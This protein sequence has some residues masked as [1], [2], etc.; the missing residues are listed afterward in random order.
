MTVFT[1]YKSGLGS[2]GSYQVSGRPWITGSVINNDQHK[3]SFPSV[4]KSVTVI[5]T[6]ASGGGTDEILVHFNATGSGRVIAGNHFHRLYSK[7]DNVTFNVK[8]KEIY[9]TNTA[10]VNTNYRVL[11]ELT[12]I[13]TTEMF[14]LTG[15][16]MTD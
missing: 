13:S 10:S 6:D 4:A 14:A 7:T 8:C 1:Q 9:I 15:S 16:G 12:G 11:A 3:I 5:N 2:V